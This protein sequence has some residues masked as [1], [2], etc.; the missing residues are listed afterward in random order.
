M[1]QLR[2]VNTQLELTVISDKDILVCSNI[3]SLITI[4]TSTSEFICAA[5]LALPRPLHQVAQWLAELASK[6][7][8]F[9]L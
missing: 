9:S 1:I 4:L 6:P 5:S 3:H 2:Q 7:V 8:P